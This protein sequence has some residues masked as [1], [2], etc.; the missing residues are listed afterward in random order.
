MSFET[1]LQDGLKKLGSKEM[2][3]VFSA[4]V[5]S[6]DESKGTCVVNDNELDY[7]DVRLV[8]SEGESDAL[9]VLPEVGSSVL[10][11]LLNDDINQMF[12]VQYSKLNKVKLSIRT[13]AL[14][15]DKDGHKLARGGEDLK[16]ILNDLII[17]IN[18]ISVVV[19]TTINIPAVEA[20]KQRLNT[21]LK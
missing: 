21:V 13:T 18:K 16:T 9:L 12:V 10:V 5:L 1:E 4:I 8:A 11:A 7:T 6:V 17:E 19:G 15:I 14:D 20:I 2:P 3:G